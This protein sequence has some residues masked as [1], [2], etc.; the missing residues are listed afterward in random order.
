MQV[1]NGAERKKRRGEK[2]NGK[3]SPSRRSFRSWKSPQCADSGRAQ[4][5]CLVPGSEK[6]GT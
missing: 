4:T 5:H 1:K 3:I 2:E 6:S